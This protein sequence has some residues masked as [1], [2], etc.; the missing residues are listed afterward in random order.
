MFNGSIGCATTF[1]V[2]D[3]AFKPPPPPPPEALSVSNITNRIAVMML[4]I[5]SNAHEINK[6]MQYQEHIRH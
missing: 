2:Y 4:E 5:R 6:V 3:R 1:H